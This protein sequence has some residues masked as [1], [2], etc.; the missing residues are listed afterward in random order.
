MPVSVSVGPWVIPLI[1]SV[2]YLQNC[3]FDEVRE[4]R[5]AKRKREVV[6]TPI[7]KI[8]VCMILYVHVYI[9]VHGGASEHGERESTRK[10]CIYRLVMCQFS[11]ECIQVYLYIRVMCVYVAYTT[12]LVYVVLIIV[13]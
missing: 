5:V 8:Y 13:W 2:Y 10:G 12:M 6:A 11:Y 3:S 1:R 7:A 9:H 4:W